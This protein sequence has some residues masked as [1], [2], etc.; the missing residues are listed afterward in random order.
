[1]TVPARAQTHILR[2]LT[3][4]NIGGPA[5]HAAILSS[6]LVP[7][8]FTTCLAVGQPDPTEGDLSDLVRGKHVR[9]VRVPGLARSIRPWHDLRALVRLL[10]LAWRERPQIIHTHM[11]KAGSL[12]RLA[13]W[14]YNRVGPGRRP[15]SRALLVYTFHGHVLEGYFSET[16]A[17]L[18]L[19]IERWLARRTDCLI[20]VSPTIRRQLLEKGIGRPE[21]WRVVPLGL[22]L[23]ALAELPIPTTSPMV[24]FGLIGR[25]VPIKHPA[26]FIAAFE[27]AA[28]GL[29][30]S[31]SIVGDGPLRPD[32]EQLVAGRGL[33]ER[34]RFTGWRRDL[35][36]V[37]QALDVACLTSWNEGTPVSL[38]EAMAASRPVIATDVGGVRDVLA[39]ETDAP[40]DIP[41]GS[42]V[43]A[44]RGL[45]VRPGDIDGFA[46]AMRALA[47]DP[48]LRRA[49]GAAGR[50][51]V[52]ERFAAPRLVRDLAHL[53]RQL[54]ALE[55]VSAIVSTQPLEPSCA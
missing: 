43:R 40:A 6:G 18:F 32:L 30:L 20:A 49:L 8:A 1:M 9:L 28:I 33:A 55:P 5:I 23:G 48:A 50:H 25:L 19:S 21:Q 29:D 34:V 4:L 45:L 44:A 31:A 53:Y 52:L 35:P 37:Y 12:G 42:F 11:A 46:H 38:I 54:L 2:I 36:A 27:Q 17:R 51:Y 7:P 15:E 24:R 14:L 22:E 13:G 16:T 39:A 26:M 47:R 10:R 3:R 41:A